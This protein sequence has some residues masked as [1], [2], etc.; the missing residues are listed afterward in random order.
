MEKTAK[1]LIAGSSGLVG[2]A[3]VRHLQN[4]GYTNLLLVSS[5]EVDLTRQHEVETF[6]EKERPEYVF[7]AAAKVGGILANV[8]YPADFIYINTVIATNVIHSAYLYN[9][10]KLLNLGS[11]CIYPRL[12]PQ[13]ITEDALLTSSLEETN[14]PY[15]LAKILAIKLCATYNRQYGT[16]FIS[17]M[18]TNLYGQGDNF[19]MET[20]HLLP[21]LLRRFHL[22]KLL[23]LEQ[24]EAIRAD[25][26]HYPIGWGYTVSNDTTQEEIAEIL[27][28]LG[29]H[30]G[31]V[32][33]WGDGNVYRELMSSDD[34]AD[35]SIYL[36]KYKDY[37]DIGEFVNITSG[38]DILLREL[39]FLVKEIV[40]FNGNIH[41]D[42]T[43][44]NGTPRKLM[45]ASK[46]NKLGWKVSMNIQQGIKDFYS[47]YLQNTRNLVMENK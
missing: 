11:S 45:S 15:A 16:N 31:S 36:M 32:T 21:M 8:R 25:L 13:P 39:F 14:E 17:V 27:S 43:K 18:P 46:I 44:P 1:I 7:L 28:H 24:W 10:K 22:A 42:T 41:F 30:K 37:D 26:Q 19:N 23:E 35:A 3:I 40:G 34:M 9:V 5:K 29:I 47:W 4:D 6:F 2:S 20:A 38:E 12:A 33:V